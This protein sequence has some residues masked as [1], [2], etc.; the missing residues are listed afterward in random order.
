MSENAASRASVESVVTSPVRR[1]VTAEERDAAIFIIGLNA[2]F[3]I[4]GMPS[5]FPRNV[6]NGAVEVA[7]QIAGRVGKVNVVGSMDYPQLRSMM[8][9]ANDFG[10][11]SVRPR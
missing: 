5:S 1:D 9:V 10:F 8:N 4:R 11:N 7:L 6:F 2:A 3:G